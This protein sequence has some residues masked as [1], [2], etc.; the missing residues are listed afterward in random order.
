MNEPT[1]IVQDKNTKSGNGNLRIAII[2]GS[3]IFAMVVLSFAI[4]P[5]YYLVSEISGYS[6]ATQRAETNTKGIIEREMQ[7]RFDATISAGLDWTV[8]PASTV[9]DK[10]GTL[11]TVTYLATNNSN[12]PIT[13]SVLFNVAPSK[14][15]PYF[16]VIENFGFT[17]QTI[18][19]GDSVELPIE[20]FID[21]DLDKDQ[22]LDTITSITLSY[23][24]YASDSRSN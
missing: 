3:V 16:K 6:G 7:V 4:I 2:C 13:S 15:G 8:I 12:V 11:K 24:F 22:A 5:F 21:P 14:A 9:S 23:T 19:P 1:T 20:F 17:D 18:N 10:I